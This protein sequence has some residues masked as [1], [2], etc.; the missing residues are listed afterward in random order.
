METRKRKN[1]RLLGKIFFLAYVGFLL[2]FLLITD[3]YGRTGVNDTYRY[4]L[5]LFKEIKRFWEHRDTLGIH[6]MTNLVGNVIIFIP[7]GFFMPMASKYRSF[8]STFA[9]GFLLSLGVE[10]FQLV[11][12]IGSF[13]VDD[14]LLNTIGACIGYFGFSICCLIRRKNVAKKK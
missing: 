14:L 8:L 12:K 3:W 13:D 10:I 4:N 9:C 2:Y 7:F 6:A 5:E 1:I 11:T